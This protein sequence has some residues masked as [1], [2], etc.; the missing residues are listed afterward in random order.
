[1][2]RPTGNAVLD[3]WFRVAEEYDPEFDY[4]D[5]GRT[6][7]CLWQARKH[8]PPRTA[9]ELRRRAPRPRVALPAPWRRRLRQAHRM[10]AA[11]E[12]L[13]REVLDLRR[14]VDAAWEAASTTRKW[15]RAAAL[16]EKLETLEELLEAAA[17]EWYEDRGNTGWNCDPGIGEGDLRPRQETAT[18]SA[19]RAMLRDDDHE[20]PHDASE[21]NDE[22]NAGLSL[23]EAHVE[24]SRNPRAPGSPALWRR[25]SS[26]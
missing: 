18:E 26:G 20:S 24:A 16:D 11:W 14:A 13:R 9:A 23:W 10:P 1:M 5:T 12:A 6:A 7:E 19:M 15:N 8:L 3:A 4:L 22:D 2:R 17:S 25:L 21:L